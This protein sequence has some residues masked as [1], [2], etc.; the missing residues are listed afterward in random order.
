MVMN[1]VIEEIIEWDR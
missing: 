1:A